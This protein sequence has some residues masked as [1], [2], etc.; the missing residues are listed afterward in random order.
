[1][2]DCVKLEIEIEC[3]RHSELVD[4][5]A[6]LGTT[7]EVLA[8]RAVAEWLTEM[9]EDGPRAPVASDPDGS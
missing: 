5:A 3:G 7:P 9:A 4:W 6:R 2:G 1:M 8:E